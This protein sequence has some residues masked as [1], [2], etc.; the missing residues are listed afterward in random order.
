M[1]LQEPRSHSQCNVCR[2][3]WA[4]SF[5]LAATGSVRPAVTARKMTARYGDGVLCDPTVVEWRV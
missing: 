2:G 4:R 1:A 3:L 5:N